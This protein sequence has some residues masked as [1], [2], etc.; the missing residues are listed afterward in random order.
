MSVD[1]ILKI[2]VALTY[3]H[4][5]EIQSRFSSSIHRCH[6]RNHRGQRLAMPMISYRQ[7]NSKSEQNQNCFSLLVVFFSSATLWNYAVVIC[8]THSSVTERLT[9][10]PSDRPTYWHDGKRGTNVQL[11]SD[12]Y[13]TF[14]N[15]VWW[16]QSECAI[17]AL[18][19]RIDFSGH[20][21]SED[22]KW[23]AF[24]AWTHIQE[25]QLSVQ[26]AIV[27]D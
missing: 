4:S 15:A 2:G 22:E 6:Q 14:L 16:V 9:N 7:L 21:S 12:S 13:Q 11:R 23:N 10:Q 25:F 24:T 3:C 18:W 17:I 5:D 27:F 8:W 20:V 26:N 1:S 19:C